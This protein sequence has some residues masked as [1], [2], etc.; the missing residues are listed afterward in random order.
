ML[1]RAL[2]KWRLVGAVVAS[3][4]AL[5]VV[6]KWIVQRSFDLG[7]SIPVAGDVVRFT[8]ILNPGA[9]FGISVGPHS[10]IVFGVL[11]VVASAVLLAIIHQTPRGERLRLAALAL[12]LG[13]ALGNLRDRFRDSGGV[14]DF[15]D[16]GFGALRWP[17]F[18]IAD[19]GVTGGAILLVLLLW[20][21]EASGVGDGQRATVAESGSASGLV[22]D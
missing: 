16:V 14:V 2:P 3:V 19:M 15:V 21:E 20:D 12:I 8:Y 13:G 10:R 9:A 22:G 6:T 11:A 1:D 4:L 5:D 7:E 17:V 18:N